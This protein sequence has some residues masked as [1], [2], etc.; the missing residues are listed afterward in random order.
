MANLFDTKP[1]LTT[2]PFYDH[3]SETEL[4]LSLL[5]S[6]YFSKLFSPGE[7]YTFTLYRFAL[8]DSKSP[9]EQRCNFYSKMKLLIPDKSSETYSEVTPY[10]VYQLGFEKVVDFPYTVDESQR[11]QIYQGYELLFAYMRN[12]KEYGDKICIYAPSFSSKL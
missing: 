9:E 3:S 8:D 4:R 7:T 1:W 6:K 11:N 12:E 10:H 5:S 2:T